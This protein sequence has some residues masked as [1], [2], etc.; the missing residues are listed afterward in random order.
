[1]TPKISAVSS[2]VTVLEHKSPSFSLTP[3]FSNFHL[4]RGALCDCLPDAVVE[5]LSDK[6]AIG[7][8]Y[9]SIFFVKL[10]CL[11]HYSNHSRTFCVVIVMIGIRIIDR[12]QSWSFS[13]F[14]RIIFM[15][16]CVTDDSI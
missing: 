8:R 1:M 11:V 10:A 12:M 6:V 13:C 3:P 2:F 16:H 7:I 5:M 4:D 14:F 9:A 15:I